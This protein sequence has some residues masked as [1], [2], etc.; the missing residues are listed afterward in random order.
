VRRSTHSL[1]IAGCT[2]VLL[3]AAPEAL[4]ALAQGWR[5]PYVEAREKQRSAAL[6]AW[7]QRSWVPEGR[8]LRL[9]RWPRSG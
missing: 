3:L 6:S 8:L 4:R 2:L 9:A 1:L 5:G 7:L